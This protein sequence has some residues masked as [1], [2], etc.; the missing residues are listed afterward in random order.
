MLHPASSVYEQLSV[1][2]L[3]QGVACQTSKLLW[4]PLLTS[5]VVHAGAATVAPLDSK[6][7]RQE[8]SLDLDDSSS[9]SSLGSSSMPGSPSIASA[10]DEN[11]ERQE[12]QDSQ[13]AGSSHSS[14]SKPGSVEDTAAVHD[15]S[16]GAEG[17]LDAGGSP[18]QAVDESHPAEEVDMVHVYPEYLLSSTTGLKLLQLC[19]AMWARDPEAR[20]SCEDILMQLAEL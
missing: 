8:V 10:D 13:S 7:Q 5:A 1:Y 16:A 4:L 12:H 11:S 17:S 6:I 3:Q 2:N 15:S 18:D 9:D 20:P 19:Q 14:Q